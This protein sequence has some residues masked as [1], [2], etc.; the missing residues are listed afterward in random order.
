[1]TKRENL[2]K[3]LE[4]VCPNFRERINQDISFNPL[5]HSILYIAI[6][7]ITNDVYVG[8]TSVP[9]LKRKHQH[10]K[11]ARCKN[12]PQSKFHPAILE[13]GAENFA[14]IVLE[15]TDNDSVN[16]RE[17]E[18][19]AF[20]DSYNDG[21]NATKGGE[22]KGTQANKEEVIK[23]FN[24]GFSID[25]ISSI[26]G[27]DRGTVSF[28]LKSAG[29]NPRD[30]RTKSQSCAIVMCDIKTHEP[31]KTFPSMIDG[32][33]WLIK[34][35]QKYAHHRPES[36]VDKISIVASGKGP[37]KSAWGYYW[38]YAGNTAPTYRAFRKNSVSA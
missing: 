10:E 36:L 13:W 35:N 23:L 38:K 25:E 7:E 27:L 31:I 6:N 34:N 14:W 17:K 33:R 32:A 2:E 5:T 37:N 12:E 4:K 30:N 15:V 21:Y 1:M 16:R 11:D 24:K 29:I 22:G 9:M 3:K 26:T 8:Q 19:I 20:F 18:L 28:I